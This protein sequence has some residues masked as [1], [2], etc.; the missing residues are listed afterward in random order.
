VSRATVRAA[1]ATF[2]Q[3]ANIVGLNGIYKAEP[4]FY[5]GEQLDAAADTGVA[6]WAWVELGESSEDRLSVPAMWPGQT[7]AGDKAVHYEVAIL[8]QYQY[9]VPQQ[10]AAP[11]T[12]DGWVD[13]E[14][15]IIQA[16]KDRLHSDPALGA[17]GVILVSGQE[18]RS[19]QV[20]ADSPVV[21]PAKVLSNRAITFRITEII[22]A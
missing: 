20:T 7:G 1:I 14:D 15:A 4:R 5:A 16:I 2:L 22:Q 21:E 18:N 6:A 17:P 19:L 10:T 8:V 13:G 9:L 12:V 3:D 11:V